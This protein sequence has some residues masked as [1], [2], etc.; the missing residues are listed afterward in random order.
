VLYLQSAINLEFGFNTTTCLS[1]LVYSIFAEQFSSFSSD[2]L[3]DDCWQFV[4][5]D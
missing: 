1:V 5:V 2:V 4:T 3:C